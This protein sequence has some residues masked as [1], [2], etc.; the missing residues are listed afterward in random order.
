VSPH[1]KTA[2]QK[3]NGAC[4]PHLV[5]VATARS[6]RPRC[7]RRLYPQP[8]GHGGG[9]GI[10]T[11]TT[12]IIIIIIIGIARVLEGRPAAWVHK[13]NCAVTTGVATLPA[14]CERPRCIV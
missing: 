9:W 1:Q 6:V 3:R 13:V 12:T 14:V 2:T 5:D 4:C 11:T 10:I 8:S 7:H